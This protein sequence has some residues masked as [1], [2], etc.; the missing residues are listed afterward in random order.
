MSDLL[1]Q[2]KEILAFNPSTR[3]LKEDALFGYGLDASS[4]TELT[5]KLS[6][7]LEKILLSNESVV[8]KEL[9]ELIRYRVIF[10]LLPEECLFGSPDED[11]P[12]IRRHLNA[13]KITFDEDL[14][15]SIKFI[16]ENFRS[17]RLG[18]SRKLGISDVYIK[19]PN[20]FKTIM[21]KQNG[22]CRV[23]GEILEYGQNLQLDHIIPWHLGDD[24]V[25]G[26]NWQFLCDECNQG[27]GVFPYYSLRQTG[28]NWIRPSMLRE[29]TTEVRY[30]VLIRDGSCVLSG[31][32]P[33]EAKLLVRKRI[34]TGCW[35]LDNLEAISVV[36]L[37]K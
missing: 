15:R 9:G 3:G 29:L 22:R 4:L 1:H 19:S 7:F 33:S 6:K 14:V 27:K 16:C 24:P 13:L 11:K 37:N 28:S 5:Q 34:D 17:Q 35:V 18:I 26:S 23:C 12:I 32:K 25:D 31:A 20:I 10:M 30:A 21:S 2:I 8:S 36:E